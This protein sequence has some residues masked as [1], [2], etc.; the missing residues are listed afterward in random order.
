MRRLYSALT[1]V[2]A[3][4]AFAG[5][6][7][8]GLRDRSY[9]QN[10]RE[11]FGWGPVAAEAPSIWL[12]AVSLGEVSAAAPLVSALRA[13]YPQ[14]P[15]V[16]STATPTG[17]ARAQALFGADVDIRFLP[18]DTPGSVARFLGR[19]RPRLAIIMETELWPNLLHECRRRCVPVGS[20]MRA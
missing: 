9:W 2:L 15:F 6:L 17:R 4:V 16:L 14:A 18:Y 8:R 7:F 10:L 12:H 20:R 5:V 11:R 1:A 13:R 19:I 3:P